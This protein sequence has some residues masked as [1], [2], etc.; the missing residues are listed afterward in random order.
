MSF[1]LGAN[2]VLLLLAQFQRA[3]GLTSLSMTLERSASLS[4]SVASTIWSMVRIGITGL[5]DS[6]FSKENVGV[7]ALKIMYGR[8]IK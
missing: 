4:S 8:Q 3:L 7:G 6:Y 2:D 1:D 5:L